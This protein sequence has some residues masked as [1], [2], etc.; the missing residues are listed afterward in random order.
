MTFRGLALQGGAAWF[1]SLA[2]HGHLHG[3]HDDSSA[4]LAQFNFPSPLP[5]AWS[6]GQAWSTHRGTIPTQ[7]PLD[8]RT[9]AHV[10]LADR[11]AY[12]AAVE[13]AVAAF[14]VWR[15]V[16]A[17]RRGEL[18][19]RMG[20]AF[21]AE[22]EELARLITWEMGK[23]LAEARGEVQEV[24]DV[25]E[26]AVGLSRTIGGQ[27]L[28]SERP[29]HKLVEQYFPLGPVAV[30][31]AFNFPVAVWSWN[32]MLALI[33]GDSV[34]WKPSEKTP[35]V[36]LATHKITLET[37]REF[38][39]PDGLLTV[40]LGGKPV[41]EWM[42]EDARFPL[43]SATGSVPMGKAVAQKVAARL[44]KSLLELGGNNAIIVTDKARLDLALR[45][46]V[47]GAVG[48][49]GQRCTTTRRLIVHD[50][51]WN[52]LTERL[53]KAY[54]QVRLG[55]SLADG[56]QMGPLIDEPAAAHYEAALKEAQALGGK[57][58]FGGKR[59]EGTLVEPT[60]VVAENHWPVVQKETFAPI[61]YL[62]KYSGDIQ[63]AI[64]LQNSVPQGLSS[65]L[66][67]DDLR[68][69]ETFLSAV[70]SDCGLA[71]VNAGTS[72]AEIGG[73]F[74]GEKETGGGR[75][76]GSDSWKA[77]MRRQTSAVNY[78]TELPLAQGIQ[79]D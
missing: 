56:V 62:I 49:S 73:A 13:G 18:V 71:N 64:A 3:M 10:P 59:L 16:P 72:G 11:A 70:G 52:T 79:F 28:P 54:G 45:A 37:A 29:D 78:G 7:S 42:S 9:L 24:I 44:G 5:S 25:C 48:T 30:I 76:S 57:I 14:Q 53:V 36:A 32:T 4:L 22:K 60:L 12:D 63:N 75:E 69:V 68:E 20:E 47:F 26:F 23:T 46:I 65:A 34:V 50:S 21:R 66:F 17:P 39:A 19:R 43:V 55:N 40:I 1:L 15:A 2:Q 38:G 41:G 27:T 6:L 67:S 77:Y 51:I 8:G 35:L 31:S 74:G 58:L 33:C 61:L